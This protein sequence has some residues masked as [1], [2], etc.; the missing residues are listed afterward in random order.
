MSATFVASPH[1]YLG[2]RRYKQLNFGINCASEL[3]QHA[4]RSTLQGI[5][6]VINVSDDILVY[7]TDMETHSDRSSTNCLKV[8]LL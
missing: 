6:K 3:F 4:V 5:N 2:L 7:S 8:V 1:H